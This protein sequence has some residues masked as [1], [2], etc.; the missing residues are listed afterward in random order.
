[1]NEIPFNVEIDALIKELDK[2]DAVGATIRS[3]IHIEHQLIGLIADQ[4]PSP[5]AIE[6]SEIELSLRIDL[7]LACG[8]PPFLKSPLRAMAKLRNKIAHRLDAKFTEAEMNDLAATLGPELKPIY[9]TV[10]KMVAD[11]G[12]LEGFDRDYSA[13]DPVDRYCFL[14]VTMMMAI[15]SWRSHLAS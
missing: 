3:M 4:L 12:G 13:D 11:H 14:A 8:M 7:A 5:E 9:Q 10:L 15:T 6:K 1:M 2:Q